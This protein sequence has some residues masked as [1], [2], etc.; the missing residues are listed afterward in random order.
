MG[1]IKYTAEQLNSLYWGQR[2]SIRQI[3]SRFHSNVSAIHKAM[4]RCGVPRRSLSEANR[5][6]K[7]GKLNP[8]WK[9]EDIIPKSG[10]SRAR[11]LYPKQL[12]HICGKLGERHHKDNNPLN[13]DPSN[14][15]WLCR[16]HHMEADGRLGRRLRNGRFFSRARQDYAAVVG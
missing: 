6:P 5:P 12:C 14:I 1:V 2:L 13:N 11:R 3:A 10:R 8:R 9:G 7:M 16:K 4:V 15:E